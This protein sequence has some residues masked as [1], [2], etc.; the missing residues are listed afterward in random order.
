[1]PALSR[2]LAHSSWG[3]RWSALHAVGKLAL[4]GSGGGDPKALARHANVVVPLLRDSD[5][6]VRVA[7]IK[8]IAKLRR[9]DEELDRYSADIAAALSDRRN[10]GDPSG[11]VR[12]AALQVLLPPHPTPARPL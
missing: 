9:E 11:Y 6:G 1:M 8:T 12:K 4:I 3:V 5:Q 2:L 7:A 10:L